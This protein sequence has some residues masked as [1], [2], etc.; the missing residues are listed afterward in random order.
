MPTFVD[1]LEEIL[2]EFMSG[3]VAKAT[4]KVAS[5]RLGKSAKELSPVDAPPICDFLSKA[6]PD[7]D[8]NPKEIVSKVSSL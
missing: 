6:L 2:T 4:I 1:S 3:I 8:I 7:F 5:K